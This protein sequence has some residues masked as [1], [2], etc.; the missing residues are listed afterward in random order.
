MI[1][2]AAGVLSF[3]AAI[4]PGAADD[5]P[6]VP[7]PARPAREDLREKLKNMTPEER[8]AAI[9]KWREQHPEAA[10]QAGD[11]RKRRQELKTLSPE[12][13]AA[14]LKER[15]AAVAA[16]LTELRKKK[17]DGSITTQESQQLNRLEAL[18]KTRAANRQ[19]PVIGQQEAKA[20]GTPAEPAKPD[21]GK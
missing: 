1:L 7:V 14:K 19:L 16:K 15:Q 3:A 11:L 5:P 20:P 9:A 18:E 17:A 10:A 4:A 6:A 13:R 8:R 21:S 12:E 2:L